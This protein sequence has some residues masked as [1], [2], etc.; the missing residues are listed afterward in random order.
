MPSVYVKPKC[1][2]RP[3]FIQVVPIDPMLKI[4]YLNTDPG[5]LIQ[6]SD[7]CMNSSAVY[8]TCPDLLCGTRVQ[9]TTQLLREVAHTRIFRVNL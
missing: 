8:V 5:G 7:T 1:F 9:S 6:T 3:P 2:F 4:N